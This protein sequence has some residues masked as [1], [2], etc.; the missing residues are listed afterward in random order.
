MEQPVVTG[1][2]KAVSWRVL[3][4]GRGVGGGYWKA[5]GG[6]GR[7]LGQLKRGMMGNVAG[8]ESC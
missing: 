8:E 1:V 4:E 2:L 6:G 5:G 7:G 3:G